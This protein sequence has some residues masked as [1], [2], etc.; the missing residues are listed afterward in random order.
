MR[1]TS[2]PSSHCFRP[3]RT[4]ISRQARDLDYRPDLHSTLARHGNPCGDGDGLVEIL[5]VNEEIATQLFT[6][7]G[8]RPIGHE[9]LAVAHPDARSHCSRVQGV[10]G[11]VLTVRF[12]VMRELRGLGVTDLTFG[13]AQCVLVT[14]Y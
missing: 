5:R 10:G 11:H 6:R 3:S 13:L 12:K 4:L 7:L 9:P 1:G 2:N 8:K 14:V